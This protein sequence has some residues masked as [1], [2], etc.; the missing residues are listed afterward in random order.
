MISRSYVSVIFYDVATTEKDKKE[1][2]K[3]RRKMLRS[4][5]YMLNESVYAKRGATY[6]ALESFV[7]SLRNYNYTHSNIKALILTQNSFDKMLYVTGE[8]TIADVMLDNKT[9]LVEL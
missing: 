8:K 7:L 1:Y 4:G 5:Y 6:E 9:F 3:M 2:T